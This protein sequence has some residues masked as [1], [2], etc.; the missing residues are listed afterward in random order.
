MKIFE[1]FLSCRRVGDSG[2]LDHYTVFSK[3]RPD[4]QLIQRRL[5]LE[6]VELNDKMKEDW[7]RKDYQELGDRRLRL[8]K[9]RLRIPKRGAIREGMDDFAIESGSG[10]PNVRIREINV[11]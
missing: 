5:T 7:E 3:K 9:W 11:C 10:I 1:T 8:A 4:W 6:L 2:P